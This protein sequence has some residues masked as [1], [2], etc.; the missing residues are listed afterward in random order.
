MDSTTSPLRRA[1]FAYH[2]KN[3]H[4]PR[5]ERVAEA[6]ASLLGQTE[7]LLDVGAGDGQ[8]ALRVAQAVGAK[9]VAGV[10]VAPRAESAIVTQAY[11]GTTL[12]FEDDAFEAVLIADVLHHAADPTRVLSE[13]LRVAKR[14]VAVKDHVKTGPIANK[15]LLWMDQVGNAEAQ[16][17]VRGT[18]FSPPEFVALAS[19]AGGSITKLI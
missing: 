1:L 17:L 7:S 2:R 16:V 13:A 15:L 8:I 12:P 18:Y 4:Q 19:A 9:R 11:D 6:L 10:D 5:V 14:V 3:I